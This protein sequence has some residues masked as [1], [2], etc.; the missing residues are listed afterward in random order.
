MK[1]YNGHS[2]LPW[3]RK[4]IQEAYMSMPDYNRY[5]DDDHEKLEEALA[6]W[7]AKHYW[8][9]TKVLEKANNEKHGGEI[10]AK[11]GEN[12]DGREQDTGTG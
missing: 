12:A 2:P 6:E 11:H 7:I 10:G 5:L 1:Q 3:E 8:I 9:V 4:Q